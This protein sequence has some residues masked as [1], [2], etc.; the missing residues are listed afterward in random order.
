MLSSLVAMLLFKY[1]PVYLILP[2]VKR[3]IAYAVVGGSQP[4]QPIAV[5]PNAL[6]AAALR[7]P[8][9]EHHGSGSGHVAHGSLPAYS[10]LGNEGAEGLSGSLPGS[11]RSKSMIRCPY[12][13][14]LHH[15]L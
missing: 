3:G 4:T 11:F 6:S 1:C 14:P 13:S 10:S 7:S 8:C 12:P 15:S 5:T 9:L 2:L